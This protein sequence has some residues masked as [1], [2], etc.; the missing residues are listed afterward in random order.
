V[1]DPGRLV[2]P[3]G[4]TYAGVEPFITEAPD[5][6]PG[7]Q[8]L[9]IKRIELERRGGV[10]R[11]LIDFIPY[12]PG[13]LSFPP[14]AFPSPEAAPLTLTGL[15]VTVA[16]ILTPSNMTLSEPAPPLA[17]PGTSFLIYGTIVLILVILF[18]G[19]GGSLWG[20]R[21]FRELWERL[22]RRH[23]L[24]AMANFLRRLEQEGDLEQEGKPEFYLSL[25]S[26]EF[27]EFLSFFTGVNC[28]S[29]TAEEFLNL[30]LEYAAAGAAAEYAVSDPN[31]FR[32]SE[33]SPLTPVFLFRLFSTWDTLRF[34]GRGVDKIDLFQALKATENFIIA[35]DKAEREKPLSKPVQGSAPLAAG[36]AGGRS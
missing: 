28:R 11:L 9:V 13:I 27:R 20:R 18:A 10:S 33:G 36:I 8:A 1:G 17:V 15:Q 21:H 29:L 5:K 24:R 25:L 2:V 22:R 12:V 35:L 30:P 32:W 7:T 14:L 23:L 6:L 3:L 31:A 26:G 16:S 34:S 19:I 4:Q